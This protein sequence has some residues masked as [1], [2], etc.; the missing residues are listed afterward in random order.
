M[1]ELLLS[2]FK[3]TDNP[4]KFALYEKI[5]EEKGGGSKR[6]ASYMQ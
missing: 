6:E 4:K 5:E 3:I 1:I 2:K